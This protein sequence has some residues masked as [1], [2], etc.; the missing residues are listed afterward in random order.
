MVKPNKKAVSAIMAAVMA[1]SAVGT[2][3]AAN[4]SDVSSS[5][6]A[7]TVGKYATNPNGGTGKRATITIDG[8]CSDWSEDMLIAQGAGWDVA[9]RWKGG[10][11]NC[12]L[13]CY[14]LYA[15]WDDDNL[16]IGWQMVN[17]TDTWA[18]PGDGPLSDGGRVLDVP[19]A[20]ALS[21]DESKPTLTMKNTN[22]GSIWGEQMGYEF[23]THVD[24]LLLMSGKVG[25]GSPS[26]F[27]STDGTGNV[28]YEPPSCLGFAAY[29]I[30]YAMDE[31]FLGDE[32]WMLDGDTIGPDEEVYGGQGNYVD[33]LTMGH[34]T[35]YDSFYEIKIP[36]SALDGV[37]A[38]YI[39]THGI[40]VMQIASRG[41]SALDCI[42]HDPSMLDNVMGDYAKDPSTTH[43]KDDLDT[44]SVP[45]AQVGA[46]GSTPTQPTEAPTQPTEAPTQP[47]T[48]PTQP[49][50]AP[51]QP[52][53][54]GEELYLG[55]AN[56]DGDINLMDS[57]LIQ[58]RIVVEG[59]YTTEEFKCAD[60]DQ[61]GTVNLRDAIIIQRYTLNLLNTSK[62]PI[63]SVI[64]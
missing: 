8:D 29:G 35:S 51:T 19:L 34:D 33:A 46:T 58:K 43:E 52:T 39:E 42:P 1:V 11:E 54:P 24:T 22:G 62:Y 31:D 36:F 57:I 44:I 50:E 61:N 56:L 47:T 20:L 26:L 21:T 13:D 4:T 6:A 16:Y 63:G 14:A 9:N 30:E 12:V 53:D 15:A 7:E 2:V 27:T 49:T 3:M 41:E 40:G 60:V 45:L 17:T 64:A 5:A 38:N 10:H 48:A 28:G 37:D 18:N 32:L 55:D 25:L 23:E 59:S